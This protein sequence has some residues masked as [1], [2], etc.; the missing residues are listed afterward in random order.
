VDS[1]L[2][3]VR[4]RD[5]ACPHTP[6]ADD[7]DLVYLAPMLDLD[8]GIR[9]EQELVASIGD[10]PKLTR[11]WTHTFLE[12]GARGWNLLDEA[13]EP[14]PFDLSAIT[15]DYRLARPVANKASELYAD[16]V[17]APFLAAQKVRSPTGPTPDTTS[18]RPRRIR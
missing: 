3:P 8:G 6:H 15:S 10:G 17:M 7:G 14:V 1:N 4:M 9:A 16:T 5:C 13:G 12:H 11:R 18:A 2:V